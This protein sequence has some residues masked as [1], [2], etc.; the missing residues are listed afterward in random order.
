MTKKKYRRYSPQFKRHALKRVSEGVGS[1]MASPDSVVKKRFLSVFLAL[2]LP[3]T[4]WA[5]TIDL[6]PISGSGSNNRWMD[7]ADNLYTSTYQSSFT[8]AQSLV[9]I[10]YNNTSGN[11]S[12]TLTATGLKP[13]FA[14]QIKLVGN[15]DMDDWSNEQLGY[16]G[17]WW[18][19]QPNPGNSNDT[20]YANHKDDPNYIYQ[21]Y[22]LFDFFS[23]DQQGNATVNFSANSSYHVLWATNDSTG[24]GTGHQNPGTNDS[25]VV[26]Y[27]FAASPAINSAAYST[28]Y[29][30]AHVGIFAEW[31]SGRALSGQLS[32]PL[33]EYLSQFVLTE[34]SF[35]QSGLGG[36]WASVMEGAV[37]FAGGDTDADGIPDG[38]DNCPFVANTGQDDDDGDGIGNACDLRITTISLPNGRAG[39]WYSQYVTAEDGAPPYTF[40]IIDGAPP[41]DTSMDSTT[42]EISGE[43]QSTFLRFFTVQITDSTG[44]TA[45]QALSV[46]VTIPNCVN[47]HATS[48]F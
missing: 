27:D 8:Y 5:T 16:A 28:D 44:D 22:L 6:Q 43:V 26:Y 2:I 30:D 9:T 38:D 46:R 33:G 24:V 35:H 21:G 32:L 37:N 7:I 12:G 4:T 31:E 47:C 18:R 23:T 45:T 10:S 3:L 41:F 11:F 25:A 29:G 20:D 39:S 48:E 15:S 19:V 40:T 42:G 34:E 1:L 14:Y 13:N 36:G 17:R